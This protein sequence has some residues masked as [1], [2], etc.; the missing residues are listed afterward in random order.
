MK[1][2]MSIIVSLLLTI[3]SLAQEFSIKGSVTGMENA[4]LDLQVLPLKHGATPIFRT[5]HPANGIFDC[6]IK[7]DLFMWHLIRI[8]SKDFEKAF[9]PIVHESETEKPGDNGKNLVLDFLNQDIVFFIQ[10][11]DQVSIQAIIEPNGINYQVTGNNIGDQQKA[12]SSR[13][14]PLEKEMNRMILQKQSLSAQNQ[15]GKRRDIERE[16][17]RLKNEIE[18]TEL[19]LIRDHP[20]WEFSA[21]RL[22]GYPV[23]IISKYFK[24]FSGDVQNSF[25][26]IHL[27]KILTASDIGTA[28]PR[29]SLPNQKGEQISS[30]GFKKPYTVLDFWGSWCGY[31]LKDFSKLCEYEAKYDQ[32]ADFIHIACRDEI[33]SWLSTIDRLKIGGINL[34][35]S[36]DEVPNKFG[37]EVFPTKIIID[38]KGQIVFKTIGTNED[39]YAK[40]DELFRK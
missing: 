2:F 31:C 14:Y 17:T 1:Y 35:A 21:Q 3:S 39:F 9:G 28:A 4:T 30:V 29:F 37:V 36:T 24:G 6:T 25:F 40:M 13:L 22:A 15:R 20:D 19:A 33:E 27:S 11:G 34:F 18:K 26:G 10:P 32:Q 7:A 16:I 8:D 5:I 12:F 23:D 38:S